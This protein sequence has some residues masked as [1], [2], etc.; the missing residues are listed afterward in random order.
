M[1]SAKQIIAEWIP[2]ARKRGN[3]DLVVALHYALDI[4]DGI[5]QECLPQEM[6]R[7]YSIAIKA[8]DAMDQGSADVSCV[9]SAIN[10]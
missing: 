8:L 5:A 9:R 6:D 1:R 7:M 2:I 3:E 10:L 4:I